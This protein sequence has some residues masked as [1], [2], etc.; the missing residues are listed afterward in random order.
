MRA[1]AAGAARKQSIFWGSRCIARETEKATSRLGCAPRNLASGAALDL[2][3]LM[4]RIR[5]DTISDQVG[6]LNAALRGHYAFPGIARNV[7]ALLKVYRAVERYWRRMLCSRSWAG[8]HF[9]WTLSTRSKSGHLYSDQNCS[10]PTGRCRLSRC[11]CKSTAEERGAGN[12]HATFCGNRRR[13][14]DCLR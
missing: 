1:N 5:H 8:T 7:R 9:T 12:P 4:R 11:N 3:E 13:R 14:G 6:E 10:F 2:Q